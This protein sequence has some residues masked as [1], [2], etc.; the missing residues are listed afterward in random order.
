VSIALS[1]S[2][3]LLINQL[4]NAGQKASVPVNIVKFF[5]DGQYAQVTLARCKVS[6]NA[7]LRRLAGQVERSLFGSTARSNADH[8]ATPAATLGDTSQAEAL[9]ATE[10][11]VATKQFMTAAAADAAGLRSFLFVLKLEKTSSVADLQG[12]LGD[13]QKVLAKG[14]GWTIAQDITT[15]AARLLK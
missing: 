12:L 4:R 7:E 1:N 3:L 14:V 10:R 2:N 9:N 13:F 8:D 15:R 11:F 6:V 5:A